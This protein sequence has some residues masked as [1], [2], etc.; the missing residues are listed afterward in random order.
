VSSYYSLC[1]L[2]LLSR[3]P[4][5]TLYVSTLL[6]ICP[7]RGGGWPSICVLLEAF[8]YLSSLLYMCPQSGGGWPAVCP[9]RRMQTSLLYFPCRWRVARAADAPRCC[10]R[11]NIWHIY[12]CVYVCVCVCACVRVC[13]YRYMYTHTHTH[14]HTCIHTYIYI[15][16]CI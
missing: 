8:L 12:V 4:H 1:V 6:Y 11:Y 3:C 16:T 7:Q 15:Y 14:T 9:C 13:M 5:T 10:R 2:I